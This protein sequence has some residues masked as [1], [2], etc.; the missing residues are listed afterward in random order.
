M[1]LTDD[2]HREEARRLL[3]L[4]PEESE[5]ED[6]ALALRIADDQERAATGLAELDRRM[7]MEIVEVIDARRT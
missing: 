5:I 6:V 3:G 1:G 4:T 2:E 7:L